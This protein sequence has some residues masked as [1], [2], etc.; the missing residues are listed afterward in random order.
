M[1]IRNEVDK[2]ISA[3]DPYTGGDA[4]YLVMD[5]ESYFTLK[6]EVYGSV[7][8]AISEEIE[9]IAGLKIFHNNIGYTFID[10]A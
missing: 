1:N 5:D 6:M 4:K 7:E 8:A 9:D 3:F 2:L 10:V